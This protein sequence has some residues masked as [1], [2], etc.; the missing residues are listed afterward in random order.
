[1]YEDLT[2]HLITRHQAV[3][4]ELRTALQEGK[5]TDVLEY[6]R[7]KAL[8]YEEMMEVEHRIQRTTGC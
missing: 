7:R 8:I 3:I 6:I 5:A 4:E 2:P 1:M